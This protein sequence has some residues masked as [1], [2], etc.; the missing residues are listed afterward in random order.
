M[1]AMRVRRDALKKLWA[2]LSLRL[3]KLPYRFDLP[4]LFLVIAQQ[5]SH[6]FDAISRNP[7]VSIVA[8]EAKILMLPSVSWQDKP[9]EAGKTSVLVELLE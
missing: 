4:L 2:C 7:I 5:R 1:Y 6:S 9:Q 8:D 3:G